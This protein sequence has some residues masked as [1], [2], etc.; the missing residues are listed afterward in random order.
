MYSYHKIFTIS[1]SIST[2]SEKLYAFLFESN[3]FV[4]IQIHSFVFEACQSVDER[5]FLCFYIA[6]SPHNV[7]KSKSYGKRY[8]L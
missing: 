7:G 1:L 3:K 4:F 5:S 6:R 8:L 2:L